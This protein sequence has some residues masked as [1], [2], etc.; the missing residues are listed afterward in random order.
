MSDGKHLF[1]GAMRLAGAGDRAGAVANLEDAAKAYVPGSLYPDRALREL[2]IMARAA[3]MRGDPRQAARIWEVVRRSVLAT[4]HLYQ[5][6]EETLEAAEKNLKRLM[7]ETHP[8]AV[9]TNPVPRP[10]DPSALGSIVLFL[11]LIAWIAGALWLFLNP[12]RR[13]GKPIVPLVYVWGGCLG[14]LG[15]WLLTAWLI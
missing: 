13:D 8:D 2:T 7:R 4:R 6:N 12:R 9:L 11:G 5:P 1:E 10:D 14:G 3:E 15:I